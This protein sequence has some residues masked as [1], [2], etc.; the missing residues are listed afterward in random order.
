MGWAVHGLVGRWGG[1]GSD[2]VYRVVFLCIDPLP[3]LSLFHCVISLAIVT[4][5]FFIAIVEVTW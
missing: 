5:F 4:V 1:L 3:K 2:G